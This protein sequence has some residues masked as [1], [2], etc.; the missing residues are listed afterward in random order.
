MVNKLSHR[1]YEA[2][3]TELDLFP[4]NCRRLSGALIQTYRIV[5]G[6][7]FDLKFDN[8]LELAGKEHLQGHPFIL[9]RNLAHTDVRK[10]AFSQKVVGAWNILP[11]EVSFQKLLKHFNAT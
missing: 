3:L 10:N 1:P 6:H 7:E 2:K 8:F 5:R 11:D 4:L 9:Q